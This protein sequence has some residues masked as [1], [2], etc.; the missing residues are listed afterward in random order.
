[1]AGATIAEV[2]FEKWLKARKM[3]WRRERNWRQRIDD[4]DEEE[5]EEENEEDE[6]EE[7]DDDE[8]E[9]GYESTSV[10]PSTSED[11]CDLA[12]TV[13]CDDKTPN[14]GHVD[15]AIV[16]RDTSVDMSES[17]CSGDPRPA[18][19]AWAQAVVTTHHIFLHVVL[20][21]SV[22]LPDS[23]QQV[24]P[25]ERCHL[26]RLSR[27]LLKRVGSFLGVRKKRQLRNAR[28]FAGVLVELGVVAVPTIDVPMA[29]C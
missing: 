21:A 22:I 20:R 26:P 8:D 24:S 12:I 5:E 9:K 25:D 23:H 18:L 6:D 3:R 1:V 14:T 27:T 11:A 13:E 16:E 29:E 2:G 19:L 15:K 7:D 17:T 4:D 10:K 28:E